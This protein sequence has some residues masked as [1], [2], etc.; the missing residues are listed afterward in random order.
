M[1]AGQKRAPDLISDAYEPP[2]GFWKLN[3]GPLEEQQSVFLT[4]EPPLQSYCLVFKPGSSST[5]VYS[6]FELDTTP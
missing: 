3:S 4:T 1:P 5:V 6:I 2:C